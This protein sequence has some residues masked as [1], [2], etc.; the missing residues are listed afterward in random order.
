MR[1]VMGRY[2]F[3]LTSHKHITHRDS[4]PGHGERLVL[5]YGGQARHLLGLSSPLGRKFKTGVSKASTA[6][7]SNI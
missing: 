7:L 3:L 4:T 5:G 1:A 2:A 6:A